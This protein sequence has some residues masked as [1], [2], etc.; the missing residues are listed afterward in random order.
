MI[1]FNLEF[2]KK[3]WRYLAFIARMINTAEDVWNDFL[4]NLL[5]RKAGGKIKCL[6]GL[7]HY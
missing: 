5:S 6:F 3:V 7:L 4:R 2:W 1:F